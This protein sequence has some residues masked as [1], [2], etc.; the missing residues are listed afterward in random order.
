VAETKEVADDGPGG[1][2]GAAEEANDEVMLAWMN[3]W[4]DIPDDHPDDI[5]G[6][7]QF[8]YLRQV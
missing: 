8:G 7:F 4:K 6:A 1:D 3:A 2:G 5:D